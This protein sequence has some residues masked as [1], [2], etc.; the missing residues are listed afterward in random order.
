MALLNLDRG[1]HLILKR[2]MS[3]KKSSTVTKD[4]EEKKSKTF[5]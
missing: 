5:I 4:G 1:G 2:V 3:S